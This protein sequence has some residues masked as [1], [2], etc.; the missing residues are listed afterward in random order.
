[1]S[2][3]II[4]SIFSFVSMMFTIATGIFLCVCVLS[5]RAQDVANDNNA[6]KELSPAMK[7]FYGTL[8]KVGEKARIPTLPYSEDKVRWNTEYQPKHDHLK[9]RPNVIMILADDLGV[10]LLRLY[11]E[12][13][14][15]I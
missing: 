15:V 3:K 10:L 13:K 4:F 1:M 11:V 8:K 9:D 2:F 6:A 5:S 7:K 12:Y 14:Y